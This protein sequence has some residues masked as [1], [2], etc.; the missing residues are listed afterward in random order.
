[1]D[2]QIAHYHNDRKA[3]TKID[4]RRFHRIEFFRDVFEDKLAE[5]SLLHY[6][7]S[8]L[9]RAHKR[10]VNEDVEEVLEALESLGQDVEFWKA[11]LE[12]ILY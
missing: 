10:S 12:D 2:V 8:I 7:A 6:I 11:Q 5:G 9:N 4:N 1:M 3:N